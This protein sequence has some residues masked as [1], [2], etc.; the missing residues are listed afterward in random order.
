MTPNNV[1]EKPTRKPVT[2]SGITAGM[3]ILNAVSVGDSLK[4]RAVFISTGLMLRTASMVKITTGIIPCMTPKATL[5][6]IPSPKIS[7]TIG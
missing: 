7:N 3:R 1:S 2:I 4:T 5:A 6:E